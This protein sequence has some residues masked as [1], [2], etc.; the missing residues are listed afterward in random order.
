MPKTTVSV[1]SAVVWRLKTELKKR[2]KKKKRKEKLKHWLKQ[3]L[4]RLKVTGIRKK[5]RRNVQKK[6]TDA[7]GFGGEQT[8]K[9][10]QKRKKKKKRRKKKKKKKKKR[11]P[12]APGVPRRSPIQVLTGPDVA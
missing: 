11:L 7:K 6:I 2:K 9:E 3:K 8:K 4:K 10:R 5:N 1:I 12:A